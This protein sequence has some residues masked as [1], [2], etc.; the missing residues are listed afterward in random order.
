MDERIDLIQSIFSDHDEAEAFKYLSGNDAQMFVD[1]V[2]EVGIC[3]LLLLGGVI[4]LKLPS[5]LVR[6]W[7][8]WIAFHQRPTSVFCIPYMGSVGMKPCFQ[9]HF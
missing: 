2:A 8:A 1:V 4:P 3:V 6:L 5:P 9:D 7:K